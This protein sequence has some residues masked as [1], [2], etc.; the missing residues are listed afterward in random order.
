MQHV[1]LYIHI[2]RT[3]RG[4]SIKTSGLATRGCLNLCHTSK[5]CHDKRIKLKLIKPNF[6]HALTHSETT[7]QEDIQFTFAKF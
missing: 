5:L 1:L 3:I 6:I 4:Y 2:L 7:G